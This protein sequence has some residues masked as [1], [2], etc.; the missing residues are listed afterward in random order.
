MA[1]HLLSLVLLALSSFTASRSIDLSVRG[2]D[3]C[4]AIP[5]DMSSFS[6]SFLP[7]PFTF[8][9]GTPV[10][11]LSDWTCR[12]TELNQLFQRYELGTLPG[13]PQTQSA[14]LSGNN[15]AI[16]VTDQGH[17]ISFTPTISLPSSGTKPFPAL[18]ALDGL[19]IPRP[20]N[21]AVVTLNIDDI[22]Q[23]NDQSSRGKGK[24]FTLYPNLVNS[25]GAM[26]AWAWATNR[27]VD[28]LEATPSAGIDTQRL[29]VTGC[30]RN[31]KGALVIGAFEPRIAL[32]IPQESGSGGTDCWRLS[33]DMLRSGITTQ[34]ASEIVQEN[35]WFGPAFNSFAQSS[36][37]NLPFDHHEL[38]ALVAPRGLLAI[39]NVGID[40]LGA[41]SSFG[42]LETAGKVY[43]A[44]GAPTSLGF[45]QAANHA[46]CAF[47]SSQQNDLNAFINRFLLGQNVST[48]ITFTAGNYT[49]NETLWTP[50]DVPTL[51]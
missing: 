32:T 27:L 47:P 5:T 15:L 19:S 28:A 34:T 40:W 37:N 12:Q 4:P 11:S 10:A 39:D 14:T 26:M 6:A 35:V 38:L 45:S 2:P 7:D 29:G 50:W 23:Q 8:A 18:I 33:D 31:G 51:S 21:V 17:S 44:L 16:T 3:A 48:A 20:S 13:K 22:A 41:P 1:L 43:Q 42:C 9:G 46:H 36:T 24:F 25:T 49:F 30:S